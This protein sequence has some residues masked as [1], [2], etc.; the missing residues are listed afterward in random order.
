MG[1]PREDRGVLHLVPLVG[2]RDDAVVL[3]GDLGVVGGAAASSEG[4]KVWVIC[5]NKSQQAR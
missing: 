3:G 4:R 5:L 2:G 1:R